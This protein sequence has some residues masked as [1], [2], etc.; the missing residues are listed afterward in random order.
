MHQIQPV[1]P[2]FMLVAAQALNRS[3]RDEDAYMPHLREHLR[4]PLSEEEC[5][6]KND[7]LV[8]LV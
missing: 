8:L 6:G 2:E 5:D 4:S 7:V 1:L 3:L